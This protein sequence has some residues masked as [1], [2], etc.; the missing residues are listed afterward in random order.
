MVGWV[1]GDVLVAVLLQLLTALQ[2]KLQVRE[3]RL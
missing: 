1:G 2:H 3:T